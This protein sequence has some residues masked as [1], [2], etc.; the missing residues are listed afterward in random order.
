MM[1]NEHIIPEALVSLLLSKGWHDLSADERASLTDY[2]SGEEEY[3]QMREVLHL[4]TEGMDQT[5]A[6]KMPSD[7]KESLMELF[8]Q[9]H[10]TGDQETAAGK[11]VSINRRWWLTG[12]AAAVGLLLMAS[13]WWLAAPD[14]NLVTPDSSEFASRLPEKHPAEDSEIQTGTTPAQETD[15]SD[16]ARE[17]ETT[18]PG[19]PRFDDINIAHP[20]EEMKDMAVADA[21][22]AAW[23]KKTASGAVTDTF[24]QAD[25]YVVTLNQASQAE[26]MQEKMVT[27]SVASARTTPGVNP[28]TQLKQAASRSRTVSEDRELIGFL[29]ACP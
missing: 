22:Q 24:M 15:E 27:K 7:R 20:A 26:M 16:K 5:D 17:K 6:M 11:V 25:A 8:D 9:E 2:V 23:Y 4:M 3:S 12:A 28:K 21:D 19:S 14:K 1:E 10:G 18:D 13:V 29:F